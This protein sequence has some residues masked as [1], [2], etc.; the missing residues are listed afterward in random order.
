[1]PKAYESWTVLPHRPIEKLSE[2]LWRVEGDLPNM[3]LKRVMTI[4]KR[5]DGRLVIHNGIA[6]DEASMSEIEG[7]GDVAFILVP[8]GHH[9]LDARTYHDRYPGAQVLAPKGA[10]A[11][12]AEVTEVHGSFD[13]FPPDDVVSLEP[14]DGTENAEGLMIVRDAAGTTLV[15]ND[16]VFNMPHLPGLQGFVLKHLTGSS[17]GPKVSRIGRLFVIKDRAAFKNH[18]ERLA[19][20]PELRRVIVSH[21]ETIER[22]PAAA[23]RKVAA[24]I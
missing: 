13:D 9:R 19:A 6:L 14:F 17:G 1:M 3:P 11:K 4:A 22:D 10:R 8:G 23:L 15:L 5:V 7:W 12:V 16:T 24:S 20:L 18:L 21:H 2:A